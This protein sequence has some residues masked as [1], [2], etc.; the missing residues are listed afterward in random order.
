MASK[1]QKLFNEGAQTGGAEVFIRDEEDDLNEVATPAERAR[2]QTVDEVRTLAPLKD[3][4]TFQRMKL[5][6]QE[7]G[8]EGMGDD[9][10][11]R[12][13]QMRAFRK[14]NPK[15]DF[16]SDVPDPRILTG[17]VPTGVE[18]IDRA[19]ERVLSKGG[20]VGVERDIP[21]IESREFD[22]PVRI[23]ADRAKAGVDFNNGLP[24]WQRVKIA[25]STSVLEG[26][27]IA[28]K[29]ALAENF[30]QIP[31]DMPR[32]RYDQTL[33]QFEIL[34]PVEGSPDKFR[35]TAMDGSGIEIADLGDMVAPEEILSVAGSVFGL[36]KAKVFGFF[37]GKG[38]GA[39]AAKSFL[40]GLSGRHAGQ[41]IQTATSY[42]QDGFAPSYQQLIDQGWNAALIEGFASVTGE[43]GAKILRS[44]STQ[45]QG[46]MIRA[47]GKIAVDNLDAPSVERANA[48]I[49]ETREDLTRISDTLGRQD[50]PV[51]QANASHSIELV[52]AQEFGR[53]NAAKGVQRDF[54]K[55]DATAKRSTQDYINE[56][57]GGDATFLGTKEGT[58]LAANESIA[59]GNQVH[60]ALTDAGENGTVHF[61]SPRD[62]SNG[63]KVNPVG[64][65]GNWEIVGAK[66][67]KELQGQGIGGDLYVAAAV[68]ANSHGKI[69]V[70]D[71]RGT[72]LPALGAW[73]SVEGREGIG[74]LV[75]HKDVLYDANTK[76]FS[77]REGGDVIT[78]GTDNVLVA[79]DGTPLVRQ[80]E[81]DP[82]IPQLI[83]QRLRRGRDPD[84][85]QFQKDSTEFSR[86]LRQPG[87][88][89]LGQT[90]EEMNANPF[91]RQEMKEAAFADYKKE[92]G[93]SG[94]S[95]NIDDFNLWKDETERVM[96]DIFTPHEMLQIRRPGGIRSVMDANRIAMDGRRN[97][98]STIL[99]VGRDSKIFKDPSQTKLWAQMKSLSPK[100]RRRAMSVLDSMPGGGGGDGIRAIVREEL[101]HTLLKKTKGSND[102]G[103][104]DWLSDSKQIIKDVFGEQQSSQYIGHLNTIGNI[105]K[106][107]SDTLMV[108]G[109][110]AD[111]NPTALGL[112]R[113]IFGPLSRAQRFLSA[114]RR[115]MLRHSAALSSDLIT[116][117]KFLKELDVVKMFPV[118]SRQVARL[119]QDYDLANAFGWAGA[120]GES[121]DADNATHRASVAKHVLA[122]LQEE[123]EVSDDSR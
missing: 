123:M 72:S 99:G 27:G 94:E 59:K 56:V 104:K 113:V 34:R 10:D 122:M 65:Q 81:P 1:V 110:G 13:A 55:A 109:T 117:P 52:E 91:L 48:N 4:A 63:V 22:D 20:P 74:E 103:F 18:A 9:W 116:D 16:R 101:R 85:G 62:A 31:D 76:T 3:E 112:T 14:A 46:A 45:T 92:L 7:R 53:A 111:M 114:G 96:E 15:E 5:I 77:A 79:T 38:T 105:L 95:L 90:I 97:S 12:M 107:R 17:P 80:V 119:I 54:N 84:T 26:R 44:A 11:R 47:D 57:F 32:F 6:L 40:G 58:V 49:R 71:T 83:E 108:R 78:G 100:A 93:Q 21:S 60:V 8:R 66:V 41:A 30:S 115:G 73:K 24:L 29:R 69:L 89:E 121:F 25:V 51:T 64:H 98:L 37:A 87:R 19:G 102:V 39:L 42:I 118:E 75:W 70:S 82:I 61:F 23:K 36:G 28:I 2:S 50:V 43:L 86:F 67:E 68:E 35:W 88:R 120:D 33:G 106:R